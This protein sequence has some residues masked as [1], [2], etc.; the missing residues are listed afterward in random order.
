[1]VD[2]V[3]IRLNLNNCFFIDIPQNFRADCFQIVVFRFVGFTVD[4]VQK[5]FGVGVADFLENLRRL[6]LAC[7][8]VCAG[9]SL[10]VF[11]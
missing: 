3:M 4:S 9:F 7:I 2:W 1:M 6:L 11:S 5:S 8:T 10:H